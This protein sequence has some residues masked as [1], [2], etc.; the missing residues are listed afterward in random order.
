MCVREVAGV[1]SCLC[2]M[3]PNGA[4]VCLCVCVNARTPVCPLGW[5]GS[6]CAWGSR[7]PSSLTRGAALAQAGSHGGCVLEVHPQAL[8]AQALK[9]EGATWF[10][11]HILPP[12]LPP[13][14]EPEREPWVG[15]ECG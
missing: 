9:V 11:H 14:Q 8:G 10:P 3:H 12:P 2:D 1:Y 5:Q 13:D 6:A 15:A 7:G 4:R